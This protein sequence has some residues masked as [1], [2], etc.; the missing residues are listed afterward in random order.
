MVIDIDGNT[1]KA[2]Y[3][4]TTGA[5]RD[6][7][8]L[9][10]GTNYRL[11]RAEPSF[12]NPS[13]PGVSFGLTREGATSFADQ[14][15]YSTSS[16]SGEAINPASGTLVVPAGATEIT[17]AFSTV[18]G[19]PG[20]RFE[21]QLPQEATRAIQPG[22]AQRKIF[23]VT[24]PNTRIGSI[25]ATPAATWYSSRFGSPP[26]TPAMWQEDPDRDG[27]SLLMEYATGGEPDVKDA[28]RSSVTNG[29]MIYHYQRGP[30]RSDVTLESL[31]SDNLYNWVPAGTM[32]TN[33]GPATSLGEPR[34]ITL[35][36]TP[37]AKFVRLKATL[38][39]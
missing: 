5:V 2:Q 39:P 10:K 32:D 12:A 9:V 24:G 37:P 19:Q 25:E 11:R 6:D 17:L 14:V 38:Q 34:K 18:S 20:A 1:L 35:P 30:G 36:L 29:N 31:I 26:Q 3:L 33:D 15:P 23:R 8:K 16:I 22:A 4:D 7:F 28:M 13:T 21:L 27:T